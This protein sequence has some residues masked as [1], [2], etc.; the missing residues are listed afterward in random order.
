M[1]FCAS[2]AD[3][4]G[5]VLA[6]D[7][8]LRELEVLRES[9]EAGVSAAGEEVKR[10]EAELDDMQDRLAQAEADRDQEVRRTP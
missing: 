4:V 7:V 8:Q 5:S 2:G 6:C 1:T 10:L 3:P 9:S